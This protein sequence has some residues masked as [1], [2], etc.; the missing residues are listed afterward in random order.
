MLAMQ[1]ISVPIHHNSQVIAMCEG[2]KEIDKCCNWLPLLHK[3]MRN[4][5][6]LEVKEGQK[7]LRTN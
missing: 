4:Q 5:I 2:Q 1:L 3:L 6:H 7:Q